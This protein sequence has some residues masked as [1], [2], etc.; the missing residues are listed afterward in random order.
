MTVLLASAASESFNERAWARGRDAASHAGNDLCRIGEV[1]DVQLPV[2]ER[3]HLVLERC[4]RTKA[5]GAVR[6]CPR[7]LEGAFFLPPGCIL[8]HPAQ[9]IFP[10]I[11]Y[12]LGSAAL[13]CQAAAD[14]SHRGSKSRLAPMPPHWAG[15][16]CSSAYIRCYEGRWSNER[17]EER[18]ASEAHDTHEAGH[19][20]VSS[21]MMRNLRTCTVG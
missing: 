8:I 11:R 7:H 5:A 3:R 16:H 19:P 4:D 18:E 6:G 2:R 13:A 12:H 15:I 21:M 10:L 20:K 1:L 14:G 9:S 17:M